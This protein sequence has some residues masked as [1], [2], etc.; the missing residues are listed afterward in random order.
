MDFN[1]KKEEMSRVKRGVMTHKRHKRLLKKAKG[2]W[3]KRKNIFR[4]AKETLLRAMAFAFAGRKLK[5]REFR[6]LFIT[7]INAACRLRGYAYSNFMCALKNSKILLNRKMLSQV[8]IYDAT[9]FDE[10]CATL[11]R[12]AA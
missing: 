12:T 2:F 3:G 10:I 9:A 6:R 4:R 5:K 7:R 8:A 11:G 1:E